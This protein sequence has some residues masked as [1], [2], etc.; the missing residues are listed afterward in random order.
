MEVE[1][2]I[3]LTTFSEH[4]P[5]FRP[6][7]Q[8]RLPP[9][10]AQADS[11]AHLLLHCLPGATTAPVEPS[12]LAGAELFKMRSLLQEVGRVPQTRPRSDKT[13]DV[14]AEPIPDE[15]NF[16]IRRLS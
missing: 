7:G 13:Q 4:H 2:A 16:T 15:A 5:A 14:D 8:R 6:G 3:T 11:V 12:S 9:L 1:A 10:P